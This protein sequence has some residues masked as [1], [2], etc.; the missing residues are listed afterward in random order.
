MISKILLAFTAVVGG[1]MFADV[2][3]NPAGTTAATTG[4]ANIL[5]PTYNALL[6]QPS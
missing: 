3:K 5:K 6:G 1:I 2:L 4:V